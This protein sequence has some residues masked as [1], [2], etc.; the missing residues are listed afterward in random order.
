MKYKGEYQ[1]S[2][3]LDPET[4]RFYPWTHVKPLLDTDTHASF[5]NPQPPSS[6]PR[7]RKVPTK[8]AEESDEEDLPFPSP[9]PPGF[10]DPDSLPRSLI[11]STL[12]L[13]RKRLVPFPVSS[14]TLVSEFF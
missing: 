13:Q 1:P 3:L 7:P 11:T 8:D 12:I 9:P 14:S 4:N 5:S 6:R 10:L 2:E